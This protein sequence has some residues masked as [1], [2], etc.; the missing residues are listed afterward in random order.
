MFSVVKS[1]VL[2]DWY[3][4]KFIPFIFDALLFLRNMNSVYHMK[5]LKYL[6]VEYRLHIKIRCYIIKQE[7]FSIEQ[8]QPIF[9]GE[10]QTPNEVNGNVAIDFVRARIWLLKC[11]LLSSIISEDSSSFFWES[12][13]LL[14]VLPLQIALQ[15]ERRQCICKLILL[16]H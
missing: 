12:Y 11:L 9:L 15:A 4:E 6:S 7:N 5:F 13:L 1:Y 2:L 14:I 16:F 8:I 10:I 3:V